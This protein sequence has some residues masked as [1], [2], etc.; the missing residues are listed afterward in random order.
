MAKKLLIRE[1]LRRV[2]LLL[3]PSLFKL[4]HPCHKEPNKIIRS[5]ATSHFVQNKPK[6]IQSVQ[7]YQKIKIRIK[8]KLTGFSALGGIKNLIS[9][10]R[11][12]VWHYNKNR[13]PNCIQFN[14]NV[15]AIF[16]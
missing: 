9:R 16:L 2:T 7:N 6:H 13:I 1:L 3:M 5:E 11:K 14:L 15:H 4:S 10:F 12:I 8:D